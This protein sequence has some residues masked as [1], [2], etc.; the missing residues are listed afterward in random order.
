MKECSGKDDRPRR[1]GVHDSCRRDMWYKHFAHWP[2][3]LQVSF[4][5]QKIRLDAGKVRAWVPR[6]TMASDVRILKHILRAPSQ[7][8]RNSDYLGRWALSLRD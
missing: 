8:M 3:D 5:M 4:E 1:L 2:L 7:D 6:G